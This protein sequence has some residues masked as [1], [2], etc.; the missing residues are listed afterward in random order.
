MVNYM[1]QFGEI[2]NLEITESSICEH[3]INMLAFIY[4]FFHFSHVFLIFPRYLIVSN[5][6][7]IVSGIYYL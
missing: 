5:F 2:W 7:A 1:D 3:E 6:W 4:V